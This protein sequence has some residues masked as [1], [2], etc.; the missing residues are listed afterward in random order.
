MSGNKRFGWYHFL[1]PPPQY[2]HN[3]LCWAAKRPPV[4]VG[5]T[6]TKPC[7]PMLGKCLLTR[8]RLTVSQGSR[9]FLQKTSTTSTH[10]VPSVLKI[11]CFKIIPAV[12]VELGLGLL[13]FSSFSF[14]FIFSFGISLTVSCLFVCVFF[15]FFISFSIFGSGLF[16]LFF[17]LLFLFSSCFPFL[18]LWNQPFSFLFSGVPSP[19][20]PGLF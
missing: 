11:Q 13:F 7:P 1:S 9:P 16:I 5:P 20:F 14:F 8:A 10:H 12:L 17:F 18:F 15:F 4:E 3:G 2:Q 6:Y 19:L